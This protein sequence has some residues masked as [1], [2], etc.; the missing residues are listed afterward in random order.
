[1]PH[2]RTVTGKTPHLSKTELQKGVTLAT[3]NAKRLFKSAE[4]LVHVNPSHA[5]ALYTLAVEEYGKALWLEE[6]EKRAKPSK[7]YDVQEVFTDHE[8]KLEKAR[9]VIP[10]TCKNIMLGIN[11]SVNS[12]QNPKDLWYD[13]RPDSE[14]FKRATRYVSIPAGL[15]GNFFAVSDDY[16][17]D[18]KARSEALY[19]DCFHVG[20]SS[21]EVQWSSEIVPAA[22]GFQQAIK[23]FRKFLWPEVQAAEL[24][25]NISPARTQ[26]I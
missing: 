5:Y 25:R 18:F 13:V 22:D 23:E 1:M 4:A 20:S 19:V 11:L 16:M 21:K 6:F 24:S 12:I 10:P 3:E 8:T 14:G 7:H 2:R 9:K 26:T 17:V 15:T